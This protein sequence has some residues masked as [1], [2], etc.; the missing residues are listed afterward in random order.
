MPSSTKP[1]TCWAKTIVVS[2][3]IKPSTLL[4]AARKCVF[5]SP[6]ELHALASSADSAPHLFPSSVLQTPLCSAASV[7]FFPSRPPS[8]RVSP[9]SQLTKT[10]SRFFFWPLKNGKKGHHVFLKRCRFSTVCGKKAGLSD[11]GRG[12]LCR[13]CQG[14]DRIEREE[15]SS[16]VSRCN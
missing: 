10:S 1:W 13:R 8:S 9:M 5:L 4:I 2:L 3:A 15:K 7:H 12:G 16:W 11:K 6:S 14:L